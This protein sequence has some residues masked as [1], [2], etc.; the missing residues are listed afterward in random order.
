MYRFTGM[1]SYGKL[2]TGLLPEAGFKKSEI[3]LE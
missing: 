3:I 1:Q 2:K